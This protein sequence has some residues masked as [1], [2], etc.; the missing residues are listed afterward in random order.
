MTIANFL[1]AALVA[2]MIAGCASPETRIY[3]IHVPAAGAA[4]PSVSAVSLAIS[5]DAPKHLSQ[6][7]ITARMSPYEV[8]VSRSSKWESSPEVMVREEIARSLAAMPSFSDVRLAS[9]PPSGY[10]FLRMNLRRFERTEEK[11]V[12]MAEFAADVSFFSPEGT[13]INRASI[14]KKIPLRDSGYASLAEGLSTAL[15]QGIDDI[16]SFV[17]SGIDRGAAGK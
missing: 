8:E 12:Y 17:R 14:L 5:V 9:R 13:A 4:A 1:A 6:P 16:S 2:L 15:S 3:S 11:G 10:Y 7:Y